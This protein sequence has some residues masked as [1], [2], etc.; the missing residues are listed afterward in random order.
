VLVQQASG[1]AKKAGVRGGDTQVSLGGADVLLGGD[2][3][4]AI[5]GKPVRSMEDVIRI[6]DSKEPGD[7][8]T[9]TL[10]RGKDERKAKVTLGNRPANAGSSFQPQSPQTV[11]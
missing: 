5:D 9:L 6:V 4:T 11:P 3:V 7:Q 8:A 1:P 2:V 10:L